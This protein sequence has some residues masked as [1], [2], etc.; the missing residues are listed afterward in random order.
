MEP[1]NLPVGGIYCREAGVDINPLAFFQNGRRL[2]QVSGG[3]FKS[4]EFVLIN[5][6]FRA[7]TFLA[8]QRP[9]YAHGSFVILRVYHLFLLALPG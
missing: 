1:G 9:D 3:S 6:T 2:S 8:K 4:G 5:G 7:E